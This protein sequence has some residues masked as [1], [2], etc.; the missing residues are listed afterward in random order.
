MRSRPVPDASLRR[1][2]R[3]VRVLARNLAPGAYART[4]DTKTMWLF[5]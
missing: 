1:L 2:A 4:M 3:L 5:E